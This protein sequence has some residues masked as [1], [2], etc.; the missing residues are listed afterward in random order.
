MPTLNPNV[1]VDVDNSI[2]A[3]KFNYIVSKK[4]KNRKNR[5]IHLPMQTL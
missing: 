1:S 2:F 3:H 4:K 5:S